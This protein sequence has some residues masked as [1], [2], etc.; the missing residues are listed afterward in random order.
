MPVLLHCYADLPVSAVA[1]ALRKP[2]GT[3]KRALHDGRAAL[4]AT[5]TTES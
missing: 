1:A 3:V 5:I 2:E 4:L